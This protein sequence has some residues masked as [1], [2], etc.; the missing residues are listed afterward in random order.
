MPSE[1]P[2]AVQRSGRSISLILAHTSGSIS[3]VGSASL[4]SPSNMRTASGRPLNRTE[5]GCPGPAS[6]GSASIQ[7]PRANLSEGLGVRLGGSRSRP[8]PSR[9]WLPAPIVTLT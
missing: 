4:P 8:R 6:W 3:S 9:A 2:G 5:A 1:R 7:G